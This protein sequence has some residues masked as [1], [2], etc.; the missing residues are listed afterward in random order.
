MSKLFLV[1]AL[2]L[3]GCATATPAA[4]PTPTPSSPAPPLTVKTVELPA[5]CAALQVMA[6]HEGVKVSLDMEVDEDLMAR[7]HAR[8]RELDCES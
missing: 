6:D 1:A 2:A 7:I 8:Q 3:A 5:D 4:V